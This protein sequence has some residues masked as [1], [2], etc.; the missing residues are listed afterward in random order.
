MNMLDAQ[1]TILIG[2]LMLMLIIAMIYIQKKEAMYHPKEI[3]VI[4]TTALG[5]ASLIDAV[6]LLVGIYGLLS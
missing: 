5:L 4:T 2:L 3:I 6:I 1:L